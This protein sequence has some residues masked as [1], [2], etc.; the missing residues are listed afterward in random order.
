MKAQHIGETHSRAMSESKRSSS[1]RTV[2][3]GKWHSFV[4][5]TKVEFVG[6]PVLQI[7]PRFFVLSLVF[8]VVLS[9]Y[10]G[11]MFQ[12]KFIALLNSRFTLAPV[13]YIPTTEQ[14]KLRLGA[15]YQRSLV[16]VVASTC[17]DTQCPASHEL[18]LEEVFFTEGYGQYIGGVRSESDEGPLAYQV[19]M[20]FQRLDADFLTNQGRIRDSIMATI[21][22]LS[23][24]LDLA[25]MSLHC[26]KL[27]AVTCVAVL[28]GGSHLTVAT[29]PENLSCSLDLYSVDIQH[30]LLDAVPIL[31]ANFGVGDKKKARFGHTLRADFEF[32]GTTLQHDISEFLLNEKDRNFFKK[33]VRVAQSGKCLAIAAI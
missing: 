6:N 26:Q 7:S 9:Y 3:T 20:D 24:D 28:K 33:E 16:T 12:A 10:A 4:E 25:I 22:E 18:I 1:P 2:I 11:T 23:A 13:G 17:G 21:W 29:D 15:R 19:I 8:G 14:E 30:H 27:V 5:E 32:K 31:E